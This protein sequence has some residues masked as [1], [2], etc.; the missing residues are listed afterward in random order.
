[1]G[2]AAAREKTRELT[3]Q[4]CADAG[5]RG[6]PGSRRTGRSLAVDEDLLAGRVGLR[7]LGLAVDQTAEDAARKESTDSRR[8]DDRRQDPADGGTATCCAVPVLLT[9]D[10]PLTKLPTV[11]LHDREV[12]VLISTRRIPSRDGGERDGQRDRWASHT[13]A[14]LRGRIRGRPPRSAPGTRYSSTCPPDPHRFESG[15]VEPGDVRVVGVDHDPRDAERGQR[16]GRRPVV[17]GPADRSGQPA[18]PRHEHRS[19]LERVAGRPPRHR[20]SASPGR[21]TSFRAAPTRRP[22]M[23][24]TAGSPPPHRHDPPAA[25]R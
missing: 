16:L 10:L 13:A 12:G 11:R 18:L 9:E 19:H 1:M 22:G 3:W 5:R 6:A 21:T 8:E 25:R 20:T 17:E 15:Q 24:A 14:R 7:A 23:R 2:A 4:A